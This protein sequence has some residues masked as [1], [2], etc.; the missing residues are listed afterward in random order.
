L[1]AKAAMALTTLYGKR[2]ARTLPPTVNEIDEIL[3]V[4]AWFR[5][6][7][8]EKERT[9]TPERALSFVQEQ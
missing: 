1:R 3:L 5:R 6:N 9:F 7:G 4:S 8:A 2:H